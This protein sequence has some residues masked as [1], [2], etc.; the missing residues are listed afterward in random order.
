MAL[1]GKIKK[2]FGFSE[3]EYEDEENN[4]L[5]SATVTP[6]RYKTDSIRN[7]GSTDA[8][9]PE[10]RLTANIS[11]SL[12]DIP[13]TVPDEIFNTVVEI[14]NESLPSFIKEN[15]NT[16][17]QRRHIY[18]ALSDSM[19]LYIADLRTKAEQH[20]EAAW[21]SERERL[22]QEMDALQA[23][24]KK[25]ED[26]NAEWKEQKLSAERQKR[27]L[28]ERVHDLEKR[29]AGFEAEREQYELENKSLVNKLRATTIQE[30]DIE[31]LQK[32]NSELREQIKQ[33]KDNGGADPSETDTLTKQIETLE[34]EKDAAA[35]EVALLKKKCEIADA[36]IND[37]N[38]RASTAQKA[39]AEKEAQLA[40]A[41]N[42]ASAVDNGALSKADADALRNELTSANEKVLKLETALKESTDK[43]ESLAEQMEECRILM[44]EKEEAIAESHQ[45]L[46]IFEASLDK[47]E[48]VK[49]SLDNQISD[50]QKALSD[51]TQELNESLRQIDSLKATIENNLKLQA[52][53]EAILRKEIDNMKTSGEYAKPRRRKKPKI[54]SIDETLDDTDWLIPT[55]PEGTNA[56]PSGVSDSEFGYQEPKRKENPPENSAQMS[57]W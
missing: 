22:R 23:K 9:S 49:R 37:L 10:E 51:K 3:T 21:R 35:N 48:D 41:V 34:K 40:E 7:S 50:L 28:S 36:M 31:T 12:P 56:R 29:I 54:S 11:P 55:P 27:A 16:E 46:S 52:E 30:G 4:D 39:L 33:L 45:S 32:E 25:I 14:F 2:A 13:D 18:N 5:R 44:A 57:L 20:T 38:H 53:S 19:K 24:S 47:F 6:I 17:A 8:T 15:L 26:S 1:F 42:A 43:S